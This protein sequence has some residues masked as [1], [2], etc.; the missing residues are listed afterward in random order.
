MAQTKEIEMK[1]AKKESMT[2]VLAT[3]LLVAAILPHGAM[4]QQTQDTTDWTMLGGN[5]QHTYCSQSRGPANPAIKWTCPI[6]ANRLVND[7]AGNVIT[8]DANGRLYAVSAEGTILWTFTKH[9]G[10]W[11]T[12]AVQENGQIIWAAGQL[13]AL[14]DDQQV[15]WTFGGDYSMRYSPVIS[16]DGTIYVNGEN[17]V[18][19]AVN[20]DGTRRWVKGM[21]S[22]AP[23]AIG[24]DGTLY[25]YSAGKH[26]LSALNTDGEEVWVMPTP[27]MS[28]SSVP[29]VGPDGTVYLS[30][31]NS[32]CGLGEKITLLAVN[33]DGT[34]KWSC[35]GWQAQTR[36]AIGPDGTIYLISYPGTLIAI[37]SDGK[38]KWRDNTSRYDMVNPAIDGDG[39]VYC[40]TQDGKLCAI[41]SDGQVLWDIKLGKALYSSPIIGRDHTIYVGCFLGNNQRV[42]C[43]VGEKNADGLVVSPTSVTLTPGA[44]QQFTVNIPERVV[45][46]STGGKIDANGLFTAGD[47]TGVFTITA[48][49]GEKMATA[50]VTIATPLPLATP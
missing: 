36:P 31:G 26:T 14:L 35:P 11:S 13:T 9:L 25:S 3:S 38:E 39:V 50:T 47:T 19:Y 23:P 37:G 6:E 20:N 34:R 30:L 17:G 49:F 27:Y 18:L 4:A 21:R 16:R 10:I 15:L 8:A 42:L 7:H 41:S 43:A 22:T 46:K 5:A 48:A 32:N 45:W 29:A 40:G 12:P 1:S 44:A 33:T 2:F 28:E 24:A